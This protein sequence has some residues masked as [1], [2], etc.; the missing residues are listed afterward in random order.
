LDSAIT[1][2]EVWSQQIVE[3]LAE[4]KRK[5][6]FTFWLIFG[7]S[8]KLGL[9]DSLSERLIQKVNWPSVRILALLY[10]GSWLLALRT[11]GP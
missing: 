8:P 10:S 2:S 4:T 5:S 3:R 1:Q 11:S 9:S 6:D 7:L